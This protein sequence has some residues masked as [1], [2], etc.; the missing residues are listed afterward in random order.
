MTEER[1]IELDVDDIKEILAEHFNTNVDD[2]KLEYYREVNDLGDTE[3]D[4]HCE[5]KVVGK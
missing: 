1:L 2:V 4:I 5:V 3:E